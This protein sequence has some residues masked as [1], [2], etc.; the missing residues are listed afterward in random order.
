MRDFMI[1]LV[2]RTAVNVVY[3]VGGAVGFWV[4]LIINALCGG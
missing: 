3:I 2:E 4:V 1:E